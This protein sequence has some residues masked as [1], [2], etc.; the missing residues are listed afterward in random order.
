MKRILTAFIA[1]TGLTGLR[2][3][4]TINSLDM[5]YAPG[6]YYRSYA[7]DGEVSVQGLL[8]APGGPQNWNF[9]IG[10]EDA[11]FRFDYLDA[12]DSGSIASLFPD[13]KLAERKQVENGTVEDAFLFLDQQ[14][15]KGRMAYG[16]YDPAI[17]GPAGLDDPAGVFDPPLLDFPESIDLGKTWSGSTVFLNSML[18]AEMRITYTSTAAADAYGIITLPQLGFMECIRVNE[19]VLT[20]Y[21]VKFPDTG[22]ELGTA[23]TGGE[24]TPVAEYYVRNMYWM[25]KDRGIVAQVTSKQSGTPPPDEFATAAQF[26]R[27]FETNHPKGST[28]PWPV[29]DLSITPGESQVLLSWTK[30]LNASSFRVEYTGG[31]GP[32]A[33]WT[34]LV[35]TASNFALDDRSPDGVR[36]YR[37]VSLK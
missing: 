21:E 19:L 34:T 24:F 1:L 17:T 22:E 26:V 27:M 31:L 35:T 16:F 28:E 14:F 6:Q 11:V 33:V 25:A 20:L 18:G 12:Q 29:T 3:Q 30:P 15:G 9:A 37:V 13:A 32:G 4:I 10:P 36:Y 8:G 23:S 5:F 7:A 2:A